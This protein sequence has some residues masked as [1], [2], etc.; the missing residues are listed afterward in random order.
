[1]KSNFLKLV[2]LLLLLV[3]M[4]SACGAPANEPSGD[5]QTSEEPTTEA[6]TSN[7]I[8]IEREDKE[9]K[10]ILMIGNS[11]CYYYVEELCGIASADGYE[12]TVANLYKSGAKIV[13]HVN[14]LKNDTR[15]ATL[16][17][18]TS[19][20]RN[21]IAMLN[22]KETLEYAEKKLKGE[23][24]VISLQNSG[25]FSLLGDVENTEKNTLPQAKELYDYI[26]ENYPEAS[27]YWHQPWA[28][29]IGYGKD[30]SEAYQMNDVEH[31]TSMHKINK[32]VAQN[33]ANEN[34]VKI[35]PTGDAWEIARKSEIVG[36][37]LCQ[38]KGIN[39]DEG[40]YYHDGDIGGGQYLNACVWY[41]VLM[42]KSCIGNTWRP[43]YELSEEKIAILQAAAHEAVAAM[44]GPGYAE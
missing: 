30:K 13:E 22:T 26:K 5:N 39:G 10:N 18:T 2:A 14:S 38:R 6:D 16:F 31:R 28:Y 9:V 44:Y 27:L 3:M 21:K 40:D 8:Y 24:D 4:L 35:M 37:T 43:S 19:K 15:V 42:G 36:T 12:L 29:E 34:G 41:E 17:V 23:W 25:A 1:M 32:N 33:V 20:G 11:F 7:D